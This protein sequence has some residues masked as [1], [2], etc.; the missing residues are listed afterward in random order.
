[1]A[2]ILLA[3]LFLL[4]QKLRKSRD[5]RERVVQLVRDARHQLP[6]RRQLLALHELCLERLLLRDVFD[7]DDR[8]LLGRRA[9]DVS[10]IHPQRAPQP[11]RAGHERGGALTAARRGQQVSQR[12]RLAQERLTE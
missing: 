4:E 9:G 5:R 11:V 12:V 7:E 8:A 10:R 1:M 6:N 2:T 3:E